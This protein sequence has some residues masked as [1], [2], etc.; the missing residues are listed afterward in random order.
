MK[1]KKRLSVI[2]LALI[3]P[4]ALGIMRVLNNMPVRAISRAEADEI[5]EAFGKKDWWK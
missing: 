1:L 3:Y 5:R 2:L 4:G